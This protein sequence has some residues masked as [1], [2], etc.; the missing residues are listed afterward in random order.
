MISFVWQGISF[1]EPR[2]HSSKFANRPLAPT[3]ICADSNHKRNYNDQMKK[4]LS[5]FTLTLLLLGAFT[6]DATAQLTERKV[7]SKLG[8][9]AAANT[10]KVTANFAIYQQGN[11]A[12]VVDLSEGPVQN[13][14]WDMDDKTSKTNLVLFSHPYKETGLYKICLTVQGPYNSDTHCEPMIVRK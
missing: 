4:T 3:Y 8:A 11:I 10:N 1:I 14:F 5:I 7:E 13:R 6:I 12:H 2:T 9:A